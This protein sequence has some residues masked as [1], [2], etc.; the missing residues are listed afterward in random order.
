[1]KYMRR[2]DDIASARDFILLLASKSS[3]SGRPYLVGIPHGSLH[4]T[5]ELLENELRL[6][7]KTLAEDPSRRAAA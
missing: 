3:Q 4:E 7:E 5:R 6:L 2:K 1:M